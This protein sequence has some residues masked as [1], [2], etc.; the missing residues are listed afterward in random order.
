M[1]IKIIVGCTD[2]PARA[3]DGCA[4]AFTL[5][6]GGGGS[7]GGALAPAKGTD[8]GGAYASALEALVLVIVGRPDA[9]PAAGAMGPRVARA[10]ANGL[11]THFAASRMAAAQDCAQS[12]CDA[13]P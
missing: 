8:V 3:D 7:A 1:S 5:A 2:L 10:G 13:P 9:L 6:I 4:A 11:L 12:L